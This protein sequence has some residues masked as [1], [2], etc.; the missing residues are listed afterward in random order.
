[1]SEESPP[2]RESALDRLFHPSVVVALITVIGGGIFGS[3]I[4]STLQRKAKEREMALAEYREYVSARLKFVTDTYDLV[5]R[6]IVAAD[7]LIVITRPEF[8]VRDANDENQRATAAQKVEVRKAFNDANAQWNTAKL[9]TG[10]LLRYYHYGSRPVGSTW[11]GVSEAV[12]AYFVCSRSW[13]LAHPDGAEALPV[14]RDERKR[15]IA[16]LGTLGD[17]L[18]EARHGEAGK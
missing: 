16:A 5:G 15:A 6:A 7:G 12:D 8:V 13:F 17:A 11:N 3:V 9:R 1:M 4:T 10:L 14:C 18:E 2:K